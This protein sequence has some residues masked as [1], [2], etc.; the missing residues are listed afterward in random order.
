MAR[1]RVHFSPFLFRPRERETL[2]GAVQDP[3]DHLPTGLKGRCVNQKMGPNP[4]DGRQKAAS[5]NRFRL[6]E[7]TSRQKSVSQPLPQYSVRRLPCRHPG[8]PDH[9]AFPKDV[10]E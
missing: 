3:G 5:R 9:K 6:R 4:P 10:L 1:A 8:L 2:H 7:G